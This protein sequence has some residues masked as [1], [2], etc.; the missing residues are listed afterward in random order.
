MVFTYHTVLIVHRVEVR[1]GN[2]NSTL[3]SITLIR[4]LLRLHV[5]P[6]LRVSMEEV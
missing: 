6:A 1:R 3:V 2:D 4:G 5:L